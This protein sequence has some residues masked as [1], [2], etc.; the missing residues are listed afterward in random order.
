M[1]LNEAEDSKNAGRKEHK[2]NKAERNLNRKINKNNQLIA[3]WTKG[4]FAADSEE[5]RLWLMQHDKDWARHSKQ[6]DSEAAEV[7]KQRNIESDRRKREARDG[8]SSLGMSESSVKKAP[9]AQ[10]SDEAKQ[11]NLL[12]RIL[13][14]ITGK[15]EEEPE[16]ENQT[17]EFDNTTGEKFK[18]GSGQKISDNLKRDI[19]RDSANGL[20]TKELSD[21]YNIPKKT[22]EKIVKTGAVNEKGEPD[23]NV[24]EPKGFM[25]NTFKNIKDFFKFFISKIRGHAKGGDMDKGEI[26]IVGEEGPEIIETKSK[27]RVHPFNVLKNM[28]S[29]IAKKNNSSDKEDDPTT[30]GDDLKRNQKKADEVEEENKAKLLDASKESMNIARDRA[31]TAK[32]LQDEKEREEEKRD[33]KAMLAA[34]Q[35]NADATE[36]HSSDWKSIFSKKGLITLALGSALAWAAKNFPGLIKNV[37]EILGKVAGV[38]RKI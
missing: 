30:M 33:R 29:K 10:L 31:K 34:A 24:K 19:I 6:L 23:K 5:A 3:K 8:K 16:N 4:Q 26:G 12:A 27:T 25:G 38:F 9:F 13:E 14:K 28:V 37:G 36:K 20:T 32:E 7:V 21:K 1:D 18:A 22:I 15:K 2:A 17:P 11:V 35:R